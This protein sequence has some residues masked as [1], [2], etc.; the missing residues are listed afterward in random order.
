MEK[1]DIV[2]FLLRQNIIDYKKVK[3]NLE[4]DEKASEY[5]I[6][7]VKEI[8]GRK[9]ICFYGNCQIMWENSLVAH[10]SQV[11]KSYYLLWLGPVYLLDKE[12]GEINKNI[13]KQIDIFIYQHVGAEGKIPER[14]STDTIIEQLRKDATRVCIPNV[15][16]KGYFPQFC[17]NKFNP[18]VPE[19]D[20][21]ENGAFPYGDANIETMAKQFTPNEIAK[22]LLREDF[23]TKEQCMDNVNQSIMEL[24]KRETICDVI[25]SDYILENYRK[26]RLF[27]TVNHPVNLV[28]KVLLSRVFKYI[29]MEIN[30]IDEILINE[31][32]GREIF[33]Y[34]SVIKALELSFGK[35]RYCWFKKLKEE[36]SDM[37]DYV[38]AYLAYCGKGIYHNELIAKKQ[39]AEKRYKLMTKLYRQGID[40]SKLP[41]KF[42]IY[43]AGNIGKSFY[44]C[45]E[46]KTKVSFFIDLYTKEMEYKGV[47]I[48]DRIEENLKPETCFVIT[49]AYDMENISNM[50]RKGAVKPII[51]SL[52]EL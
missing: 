2:D 9:I 20:G 47:P 29:D 35:E 34:P 48:K 18:T 11:M 51:L 42:V 17:S 19:V 8:S 50:L 37:Y 5:C 26:I 14:F 25:I 39:I 31:N 13:L 12:I 28:L 46:D 41:Q 16:F 24:K 27:Y 4:D 44:D 38:N 32:D 15:Y 7:K 30:D 22:E 43:G 6:E 40:E 3:S 36:P 49:P 10:S 1:N 23:Y 33:V 45:L 21:G 52:E